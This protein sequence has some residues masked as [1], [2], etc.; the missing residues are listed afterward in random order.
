M[1][2]NNEEELLKKCLDVTMI[3]DLKISGR[4]IISIN[5]GISFL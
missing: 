3:M 4:V 2:Y 5:K 1:G